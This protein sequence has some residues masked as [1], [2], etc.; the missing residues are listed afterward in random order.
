MLLEFMKNPNRPTTCRYHMPHVVGYVVAYV[1]PACWGRMLAGMR[2][3]PKSR[4]LPTLKSQNETM[5]ATWWR[6]AGVG[7]LSVVVGV[8]G[9]DTLPPFGTTRLVWIDRRLSS[10]KEGQERRGESGGRS[11]EVPKRRRKFKQVG[12]VARPR[13]VMWRHARFFLSRCYPDRNCAV[14]CSPNNISD[15]AI[16]LFP[17]SVP[18][19]QCDQAAAT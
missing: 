3:P 8:T 4:K 14:S 15:H 18:R 17:G 6:V 12:R 2:R 1:P 10:R 19:G 13:P 9:Q 16:R 5:L 7:P 11:R